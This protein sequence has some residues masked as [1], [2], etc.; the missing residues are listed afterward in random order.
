MQSRAAWQD[1]RTAYNEFLEFEG[2]RSDWSAQIEL[3]LNSHVTRDG[4]TSKILNPPL[5]WAG[6]KRWFVPH[7]L[8]IWNTHSGARLV[9][10]FC[11]G[12]GVALSLNPKSALLNDVNE[13]AINLY[14]HIKHG[15]KI[16]LDME[17]DE[18]HY[19]DAREKFNKL[20]QT[21]RSN[22]RQA[23]ELFYYL[24]RSC[25]NGLCRFNR[26]GEFN[27]PFGKYASINYLTDFRSYSPVFKR[28]EFTA[29][30]FEQLNTK[31]RDFIYADPPYDVE[32]T[33][34][35]AQKFDWEDQVRL[36][37]WLSKHKGPVVL[38][39]QAT[40]RILRLY[41]K[42]GFSLRKIEGPR[43]ISCNGDRGFQQEVM[44]IK[45]I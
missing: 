22:S 12:L 19:Y 18:Q 42:M 20:V 1:Q 29:L 31:N 41:R 8:P 43:R 5:K 28:W 44:A 13:H 21:G 24:N 37:E 39:N 32:F 23:A 34:Y 30:D 14:Q 45:N 3:C 17:N 4:A 9:E 36:A 33:Q 7:L 16:R 11:G 35:T 27:V 26:N 38:S 25:Y 15:F 40:S 6:G 2:Y 10:P